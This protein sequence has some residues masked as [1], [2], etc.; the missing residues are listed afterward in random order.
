MRTRTTLTLPLLMLLVPT[1]G[2][3]G[4][5]KKSE[6]AAVAG[7]QAAPAAEA[8]ARAKGDEGVADQEAMPSEEPA[9]AASVEAESADMDAPGDDKVKR[10]PAARPSPAA[11]GRAKAGTGSAYGL[12]GPRP[13][14]EFSEQPSPQQPT[15][16]LQREFDKT[17]VVEPKPTRDMTFQHYGVNPTIDTRQEPVST[18]AVD[19][20]HTGYSMARAFLD[21][22]NMPNEGAIRVEE[23]VNAFDYR[24]APPS[25]ATFSVHAEA[26]PSPSRTGYHVVHIGLKGKEVSAA[27][28][29]PAHLTFVIDVSGSMDMENRLGLVKRSLRLLVDQLHESDTVAIVTYGSSAKTV[30]APTTAHQRHRILSV[31]DS[32]RTEGATNAAAGLKLG[33]AVASQS[34]QQGAVNRVVLCSDGVANVGITGAGGILDT[35]ARERAR[36]IT[37]STIGVGMGNYNDVLLEQLA[38]K[39]NGNYYYVDQLDEARRVFVDNLTGTLQVIAKDVKIQVEFDP[40]LVARYRLI[41]YENRALAK[42]DFAN[43]RVDAGEI[44]AGHAVTALYEVK[45]HRTDG[46]FGK[47]RIR[48]KR[49]NGSRSELV[50]H[51]LPS[52]VVRGSFDSASSPTQLSHV[53]ATF[54]EKLRGSYWV[55][56]VSYDQILGMYEQ[57]SSSIKSDERVAELGK[58]IRKAQSLDSRGDKFEQEMP[59][60]M[61]DFDRVPVLR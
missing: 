39:G 36:G 12:K 17:P 58:L 38:D 41:G 46:N 43:D 18:F 22:G 14:N 20:D 13:V 53:A 25:E 34:F 33:Y 16:K 40:T 60:A 30:L 26:F 15:T 28:R 56:N 8:T 37:I 2:V 54:G 10:R 24:Y 5:A 7:E 21:R 29:K 52:S 23:F 59:V 9:A 55:R 44:G 1:F 32:L 51:E 19:V 48:F 35:V 27:D 3:W 31:I 50:Q 6:D 47:L 42:R 57:L 11:P 49:P 45:F 4:C 61:M